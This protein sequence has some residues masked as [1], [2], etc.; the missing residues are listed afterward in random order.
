MGDG[1]VVGGGSVEEI[2]NHFR[3]VGV[4]AAPRRVRPQSFESPLKGSGGG[5]E[6]SVGESVGQLLMSIILGKV[7]LLELS[8]KRYKSIKGGITE[9]N[10]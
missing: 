7:E 6:S 2:G 3:V 1:I 5:D 4:S 10:R 9:V 8:Q